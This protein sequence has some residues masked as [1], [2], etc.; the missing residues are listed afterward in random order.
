[1]PTYDYICEKCGHRFEIQHGMND[2]HNGNCPACGGKVKRLITGGT[3]YI[4]KNG[5]TRNLTGN[6][7]KPACGRETTCCGRDSACGKSGDCH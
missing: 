4:M 7:L 3:G 5:G 1:M 6:K 2:E